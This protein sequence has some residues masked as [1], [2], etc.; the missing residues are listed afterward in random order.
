MIR[1][2]ARL[3]FAVA[4]LGVFAPPAP[5]LPLAP[6]DC[7]R[8][9]AEQTNLEA[10]GVATDMAQ[11][12]EWA[13]ANLSTDR[14]KRVQ[15]WIELQERILFRCPRPKPPAAAETARDDDAPGTAPPELQ[16][17]KPQ[18]KPKPV[19]P[20]AAA[21]ESTP[22]SDGA[23]QPAEGGAPDRAVKPQQK[24]PKSDDA[25]K[26]PVQLQHAAPGFS[27]PATGGAVIPP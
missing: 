4:A 2:I 13:R 20:A 6:E 5:A 7:E 17:K 3:S 18:Q 25:Y 8:A 23:R 26:P 27:G 12:A 1:A 11:G 24:K 21:A 15:R 22:G 10:A 19:R 9:R 14:L 16:V